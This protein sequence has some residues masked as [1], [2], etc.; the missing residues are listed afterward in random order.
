MRTVL[1]SSSIQK[2]HKSEILIVKKSSELLTYYNS[3]LNINNDDDSNN[4]NDFKILHVNNFSHNDLSV[5]II[6][7][8]IFNCISSFSADLMQT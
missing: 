4:I 2:L 7:F 5:F 3:F 6:S 8:N 1:N